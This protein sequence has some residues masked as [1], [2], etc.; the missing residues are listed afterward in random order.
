MGGREDGV[1]LLA[2]PAVLAPVR[3][4]DARAQEH[5]EFAERARSANT[6]NR[7]PWVYRI[8][9]LIWSGAPWVMLRILDQYAMHSLGI[10]HEEHA[11]LTKALQ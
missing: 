1:E 10:V 3:R 9:V 5:N 11:G 7:R 8:D 6:G 2:L 4:E